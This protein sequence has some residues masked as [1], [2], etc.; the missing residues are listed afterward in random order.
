MES[1]QAHLD[2]LKN[3]W[4]D[5]WVNENN[6]EFIN[7]F[8]DLAKAILE[9]VNAA[10]GLSTVLVGAGGIFGV[11]KAKKSGIL[12]DWLGVDA[13][14]S[15]LDKLSKIDIGSFVDDASRINAVKDALSGLSSAQ[16]KAVIEN[17]GFVGAF[18]NSVLQTYNQKVASDAVTTSMKKQAATSIALKTTIK[19]LGAA[20]QTALPWLIPI[21]LL[22]AGVAAYTSYHKKIE[23]T[24]EA[25]EECASAMREFHDTVNVNVKTVKSLAEKYEELSKGV[26]VLGENVS[27]T[28]DEYSEYQN[29]CNQLA[30][31]MPDLVD[32]Y[33][34]TGT[35][36][37][38]TTGNVENLTRAYEEQV[39]AAARAFL[40][41]DK[42]YNPQSINDDYNNYFKRFGW[43]IGNDI[44]DIEKRMSKD[45]ASSDINNM[46]SKNY[47]DFMNTL[48]YWK[49][50]GGLYKD[51]YK[52][53]EKVLEQSG[54][55]IKDISEQDFSGIRNVLSSYADS[56]ESELKENISN[57]S[58]ILQS[59]L[60]QTDDYW[61]IDNDEAAN[62]ISKFISNIDRE[63][64]D[65]NN[66]NQLDV[67]NT[68]VSNLAEKVLENQD[69]VA[70]VFA[71]LFSSD[72]TIKE[73]N[74]A[75]NI[76]G[77]IIG[78]NIED[79]IRMFGLEA[80]R[81]AGY[82]LSDSIR[83]I[84]EQRV[85]G[86]AGTSLLTGYDKEGFDELERF[87]ENFTEKQVNL[88]I[89]V[90]DGIYGAEAAINAYNDAL[91]NSPKVDIQ[92]KI[93]DAQADALSNYQSKINSISSALSEFNSMTSS[94]IT[95]LMVDFKEYAHVF[96]EFGVTGVEG[97]GDL[98]GALRKIAD[99]I[100]DKLLTTCPELADAIDAIFDERINHPY[101]D[102]QKVRKE[103]EE[104]VKLHKDM[105][106][107]KTM[108]ETAA[109]QLIAQYPELA[110]AVR[111]VG[112]AYSFEEDALVDLINARIDNVNLI[113]SAE[114]ES[115]LQLL[116]DKKAEI[117]AYEAE[118]RALHGLYSNRPVEVMAQDPAYRALLTE[119]NN[120]EKLLEQQG[121]LEPYESDSGSNWTS[122]IVDGY[123][124]AVDRIEQEISDLDKKMSDS[125]ISV[126][127]KNK[128]LEEQLGY[129]DQLAEVHNKA[130]ADYKSDYYSV[131]LSDDPKR[132]KYLRELIES[133]K[134]DNNIKF[135]SQV[136]EDAFNEALDY[137]ENYKKS[138]GAYLDAIIDKQDVLK[139]LNVD[140]E[141]FD[142][143]EVR[144]KYLEK[145]RDDYLSVADDTAKSFE[146]RKQALLD[147][148]SLSNVDMKAAFEEGQAEYL[149]QANSID[150]SSVGLNKENIEKLVAEGAIILEDGY[151]KEQI[152]V[153][154]QYSEWINKANEM[155]EAAKNCGIELNRLY[156]DFVNLSETEADIIMD[157]ARKAAEKYEKAMEDAAWSNADK[158]PIYDDL[159]NQQKDLAES[160]YNTATALK[161]II[162]AL[163]IPEDHEL[164][165]LL[166]KAVEKFEKEGDDWAAAAKDTRME[167]YNDIANYYGKLIAEHERE[168]SLLEK[169]LA[170]AEAQ[171]FI[172]TSRYYEL[173]SV[174]KLGELE[175]LRAQYAAQDK[176]IKDMLEND[177]TFKE[178]SDKWN[179]AYESLHETNLAIKEGELALIEYGNAI[180]QI[181]WDVFDFIREQ[182]SLITDEAD[183]LIDLLDNDKLFGDNGQLTDAGL[184]VM[185][186][187]GVNYEVYLKE[188]SNYAKELE[189]IEKDIAENPNDTKL[190]ERKNEVLSLY[191]QT[192]LA[193]EGEKQATID[194]VEEGLN[195]ELEALQE[196]IDSYKEARDSAKDLYDWQKKSANMSKTIAQIEKQ[197]AAYA[198]DT[199]EESRIKIQ[200]LK[201]Q[202]S[203][204]KSDMED[205][206]YDRYLQENDE[207][208]TSLY[209]NYEKVLMSKLDDSDALFKEMMD[210]VNN[211]MG[212]ISTTIKT[213]ANNAGYKIT[214][215]MG[216]IWE[217]ADAS[218]DSAAGTIGGAISGVLGDINDNVDRMESELKEK[219]DKEFGDIDK[220]FGDLSSNKTDSELLKGIHDTLERYVKMTTDEH[221]MNGFFRQMIDSLQYIYT[222]LCQWDENGIS[223]AFGNG[224]NSNTTIPDNKQEND[225]TNEPATEG[226]IFYGATGRWCEASDGTGDNGPVDKK[227]PD[228]WILEKINEGSKYPYHLIGYKNNGEK[229]GSGWVKEL[230]E[231]NTGLVKAKKDHL[232]WTQD[233]GGE[234]II[235]PSTGAVL[236]PIKMGDSV[237]TNESTKRLFE[238]I[239]D[240][241]KF[242]SNYAPMGVPV[243][244]SAGAGTVETEM[245][246]QFVL[247]NV[248][249]YSEFVTQMQ[250]DKKFEKM[251]Q[252][253]T[254]NQLSGG[255]PMAKYKYRFN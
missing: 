55:D 138:H 184:S 156:E 76:L 201:N 224:S 119:K 242:F 31:I 141:I 255:S 47:H 75:L 37:L 85:I 69:E 221:E 86:T 134:Y 53:V 70:D 5:F 95:S 251:V 132:E 32:Y 218:I 130:A 172:T 168:S 199:S 146:E 10:G 169:D 84:S 78:V 180:R 62:A 115:T 213:E 2:Q 171:G 234:V 4:D 121:I 28:N 36:I 111:V 230:P 163:D 203:E 97:A 49:E 19:G 113:S 226:K 128:L 116:K 227:D 92:F 235:S 46:L 99:L 248:S 40:Y 20:I 124:I 82:R 253:M 14:A 117:E 106:S 72:A 39:K 107:G 159:I 207:L 149:K 1:I 231:Y 238:I 252:D 249:N 176:D 80:E 41:G 103:Y 17:Q 131:N 58:K 236:T 102:I 150:F 175:D 105:S 177:P 83:R 208:L 202:L 247:P 79:I 43:T 54:Y 206:Q 152:E 151:T 148:I 232:A 153:I 71:S 52:L 164:Y 254:I 155:G 147:A 246:V 154:N 93:T 179:E 215:E 182:V 162:E 35:A 137:Y 243:N 209:E 81:D 133:G 60:F 189:D 210:K 187:H 183:F 240:P 229:A 237:L 114:H 181:E 118:Y 67:Q 239:H 125:N 140:P 193:A 104:L 88:W 244:V 24:A 16:A 64:I 197:L 38:K 110:D 74:S 50:T 63:F 90:T 245:N 66:L 174:Q 42:D 205:A 217:K 89:E 127:E 21:A 136:E 100:R 11:F 186:L 225:S 142:W 13:I 44:E 27:L 33:D 6:R 216:E 22:S 112:D 233:G 145:Q 9:A 15:V 191:Q 223:G 198:N 57:I 94:D 165:H 61:D 173:M 157:K 68:F 45:V 109:M 139:E 129:Y 188:A 219:L 98:Q 3:S 8:L 65:K 96:E 211:N 241:A 108:D 120:I 143:I 23:E 77:S 200:E 122:D 12:K 161:S 185:G 160:S 250:K 158:A 214:D 196:L 190:I 91:K 26:N 170:K 34:K 29:I 178:G 59:Q 228:Y 135:S 73:I 123:E 194:L 192:I 222:M 204:A 144:I 18:K 51:S 167:K 212:A 195:L 48:E 56:L 220:E 7:F 30:D 166:M 126:E 87:T 101:G 25:A